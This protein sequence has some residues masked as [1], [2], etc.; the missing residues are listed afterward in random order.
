M[1]APVAIEEG[2]LVDDVGAGLHGG[3]RLG[4]GLFQVGDRA[5]GK[6]EL[7]GLQALRPESGKMPALML[8]P[9]TA[10]HVK[11]RVVPFRAGNLSASGAELELSQVLA[12]EKARPIG[13]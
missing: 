8:E 3:D 13:R 2:A 1:T 7:D 11:D 9:P 10:E 12:L 5:V 4:V 6:R